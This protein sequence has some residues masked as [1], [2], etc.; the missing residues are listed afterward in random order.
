MRDAA[1]G[2]CI[3]CPLPVSGTWGRGCK[4]FL[5]AWK[6]PRGK[7]GDGVYGMFYCVGGRLWNISSHPAAAYYSSYAF[8]RGN[9]GQCMDRSGGMVLKHYFV[10]CD[11]EQA[12]IERLAEF[13]LTRNMTYMDLEIFSDEAM[14]ASF[15]TSHRV[16]CLLVHEDVFGQSLSL[17]HI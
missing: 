5:H 11:Q 16:K 12:Y 2:G 1:S 17:I 4:A 6:L 13:I 8:Y 7:A 15:C 9:F 14:A 3:V 10:I